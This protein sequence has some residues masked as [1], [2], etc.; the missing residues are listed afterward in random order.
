MWER[1]VSVVGKK[2]RKKKA[3][4]I[5]S[6]GLT[7][8]HHISSS[9]QVAVCLPRILYY[10]QPA[11]LSLFQPLHSNLEPNKHRPSARR[12]PGSF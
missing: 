1:G 4:I 2:Y 10:R 8:K 5:R 7:N 12:T 3:A 6:F 11:F 9:G